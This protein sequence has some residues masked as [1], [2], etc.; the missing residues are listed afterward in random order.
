MIAK[1]L[2]WI[3]LSLNAQEAFR[4]SVDVD[5]VLLHATV[6]DREGQLVP[7]LRE[8]D[9]E[10]FEDGV[11][12]AVRLFRHEDAPVTAG[13]VVDHSGSMKNKLSDVVAGARRFARAS[14]PLDQM[15][16][17]NFNEHV[18]MPQSSL[19]QFSSRSDELE[20]AITTAPAA[21]R[22]AL[23]DAIAAALARLHKGSRDRRVLVVFSDGGDN[24]SQHSLA[25]VLR[26]SALSSAVIYTI[27]IFEASD[28]DKNPGVLRQLAKATGGEAFFPD[29][30]EEIAAVCDRIALDIRQHY[31]IG[32]VSSNLARDGAYRSIRMVA[33][34]AG[35]KQSVRVRAG[36][37]AG[38]K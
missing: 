7:D 18:T 29:R 1:A 21:G 27:G 38:G 3:A 25:D 14:H 5:L 28:P 16:V 8:E 9:I 20:R 24:A 22:T 33:R 6:R 37:I 31:T 10:I 32:F 13:L 15:F 34:Q 11:R 2:F 36:Y 4:I 26:L 12:Q 17:V 23:Y 30:F 35:K 19:E